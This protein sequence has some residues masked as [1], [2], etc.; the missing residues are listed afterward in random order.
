MTPILLSLSPSLTSHANE[1]NL[2][3][4]GALS[5]LILY[6]FINYLV[7]KS[8]TYTDYLFFHTLVFLLMLSLSGLAFSKNH[9]FSYNIDNI[10]VVLF[11][12]ASL[13][14]SS[15]TRN[16]LELKAKSPKLNKLIIN[17]QFVNLFFFAL[18]FLERQEQLL[19]TVGMSFIIVLLLTL[20]GIGI[21]LSFVQKRRNA[22]FYTLGFLPILSSLTYAFFAYLNHSSIGENI[23]YVLELSILIE[24]A[25][26]SFAISYR[27]GQSK[28]RL[29]QNE[30]LFKELSHRVKNNLQSIISILSLQKSRMKDAEVK[31][32]LNETI[33]RVRSISL[34]HEKLQHSELINRVNM[35]E[36]FTSLIEE[37]SQVNPEVKF[38]LECEKNLDLSVEKLTPLALIIN[39]LITNSMK[40]AFET[41]KSPLITLGFSKK[42]AFYYFNYSDNGSG[43]KEEVKESLG[44]LLINTLS[45]SQLKGEFS[46]K[47]EKNYHFALSF[48]E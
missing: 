41:S 24:A 3:F 20:M 34:I 40:H 25:V 26:F 27:Y 21:Y 22:Q 45:K 28:I 44:T 15:F 23:I 13:S 31:E 48:K 4:F 36:F 46:V 12:L 33:K 8:N 37:F 9:F 19:I 1:I 18:S 10:P 39:E 42:E 38:Q 32:Q 47:S 35:Q 2:L 30:L 11:L 14:F 6:N 5:M 43:F 17:L 7:L 29:R 16:F